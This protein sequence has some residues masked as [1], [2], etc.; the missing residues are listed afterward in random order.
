MTLG[1][2]HRNSDSRRCFDAP[3]DLY[4]TSIHIAPFD[5]VNS[6]LP[7]DLPCDDT[8]EWRTPLRAEVNGS[9]QTPDSTHGDDGFGNMTPP[10]QDISNLNEP[11][12]ES[13]RCTSKA[14]ILHR[15]STTSVLNDISSFYDQDWIPIVPPEDGSGVKRDPMLEKMRK[16]SVLNINE[17]LNDDPRVQKNRKRIRFE[18]DDVINSW[19]AD[20]DNLLYN[21][22]L[23]SVAPPF[24]FV[25]SNGKESLCEYGRENTHISKVIDP[26]YAFSVSS[27]KGITS[28]L[29]DNDAS[30]QLRALHDARGFLQ[31][32]CTNE[33]QW[34]WISRRKQILSAG[35]SDESLH[36]PSTFDSASENTRD[37]VDDGDVA[38]ED[39]IDA[40]LR[41]PGQVTTDVETVNENDVEGLVQEPLSI[42]PVMKI[43]TATKPSF[44]GVSKLRSVMWK[45]IDSALHSTDSQQFSAT[46][47]ASG[48]HEQTRSAKFSEV[49]FSMIRKHE[50]QKITNDGALSPAFFYFALLFLAN[51]RGLRLEQAPNIDDI[52][53]S[54]F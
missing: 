39:S 16:E 10:A 12:F 51:E 30:I 11:H 1:F 19:M 13:P 36:H 7:A 26:E 37:E 5:T 17:S 32:F 6:M 3:L 45:Y 29:P 22:K 38:F 34:S 47:T 27:T 21:E 54:A 4:G 40:S 43:Q 31:P 8:G 23:T 49:V 42:M 2:E 48:D 53:I 9:V 25:N 14:E 46:N 44:I 33:P 35:T 15:L 50:I 20:E 28:S 24:T 18:F 52:I 41:T